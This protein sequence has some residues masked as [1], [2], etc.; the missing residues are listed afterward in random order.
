MALDDNASKVALR[1]VVYPSFWSRFGPG[2]TSA[3]ERRG[4]TE[5]PIHRKYSNCEKQEASTPSRLALEI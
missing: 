3:E 4:L 5:F 1:R 2:W